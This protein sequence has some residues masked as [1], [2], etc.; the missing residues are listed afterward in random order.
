MRQRQRGRY[1]QNFSTGGLA[2]GIITDTTGI[3]CAIGLRKLI[4][5]YVGSA[6]NI[7]R[8]SDSATTDIGFTATGE[9]DVATATTFKGASTIKVVTWYDQSG[10]GRNVTMGTDA[11]RPTLNLSNSS[12]ASKA[13]VDFVSGSSTYLQSSAFGTS[14]DTTTAVFGVYNNTTTNGIVLDTSTATASRI[15][16][17]NGDGATRNPYMY[18]G[19]GGLGS[20]AGSGTVV[21][22]CGQGDGT[23]DKWW[24]NDK[25]TVTATG[26][27]GT[28]TIDGLTIGR[29]FGAGPAHF[30]GSIRNVVLHA[31]TLGTAQ[32]QQIMQALADDSGVTIA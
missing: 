1:R 31:G 8:A 19:S 4:S 25:T 15:E 17:Y 2:P 9:F 12:Y 6:C 3:V 10:N 23:S 14:Y 11:R 7:V 18:G 21:V 24:V 20:T 27:I 13:T 5:G 22:A 26:S 32:R 30:T 16:F 28:C 29:Y